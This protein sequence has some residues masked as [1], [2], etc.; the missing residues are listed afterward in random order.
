M[1]AVGRKVS[2]FPTNED[3]STP[4]AAYATVNRLWASGDLGFWRRI[5]EPSLAKR[6][7]VEKGRPLGGR[8]KGGPFHG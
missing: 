6:M 4:E 7:P 5:S 8:P 2:D 3:L 1:Y